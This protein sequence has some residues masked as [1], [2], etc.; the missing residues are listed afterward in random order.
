MELILQKI[1]AQKKQ[2]LSLL[3]KSS[4]LQLAL[5][6]PGLSI[7]GEIKRCSPS[8]GDL[9]PIDDPISL[10]KQYL[11]GGVAAVSVLTEQHYFKGSL[12]DL[13]R[14]K[15]FLNDQPIPVLRKDFIIDKAQ[16]IEAVTAGADAVLLIVSLL[17]EKLME[18]LQYCEILG[19]DAL[20]EVHEL[21]ELQMAVAAG[22]KIIGINNRN[23][24]DFTV[25]IQHCLTLISHIPEKIITVAESGVTTPEQAKQLYEAGFDGVLI[26]SG[27]VTAADPQLFLK[28]MGVVTS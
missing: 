15:N 26:G 18:F 7:I 10:L 2:V 8:A 13:R 19:L 17:G 28:K 27:L 21:S 25:D 11:A 1:I 3:P 6:K 12:K 20:V 4:S 22:A 14:V 16:L 24:E 9:A 23:L 5:T